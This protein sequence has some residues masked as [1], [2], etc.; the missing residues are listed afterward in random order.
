MAAI[1]RQEVV[2]GILHM[3]DAFGK[4][5]TLDISNLPLKRPYDRQEATDVIK[6]HI[7]AVWPDIETDVTI[8]ELAPIFLGRVEMTE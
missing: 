8:E 1:T 2:N 7:A 5:L 3:E 4:A 6:A